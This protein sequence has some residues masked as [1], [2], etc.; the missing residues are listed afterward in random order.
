MPVCIWKVRLEQKLQ[1][2][3]W[4]TEQ[5]KSWKGVGKK[6]EDVNLCGGYRTESSGIIVR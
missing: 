5:E 4:K 2:D 3:G 6:S 1:K